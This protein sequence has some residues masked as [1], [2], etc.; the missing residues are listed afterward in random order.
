[1]LTFNPIPE[2]P[3]ELVASLCEQDEAWVRKR[4]KKWGSDSWQGGPLS[5]KD[6]L[7]VTLSH[8]SDNA[9]RGKHN[10]HVKFRVGAITHNVANQYRRKHHIRMEKLYLKAGSF[11]VELAARTSVL[12]RSR[13]S[14]P[15]RGIQVMSRHFDLE[16]Y[17]AI[18]LIAW[19]TDTTPS[20][21]MDWAIQNYINQ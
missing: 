11:A 6:A 13:P 12:T 10:I 1:M 20:A 5:L 18:Q 8:H 3:I 17:R 21:V 7:K 2:V 15:V 19:S 16:V 14:P 4:M 9:V